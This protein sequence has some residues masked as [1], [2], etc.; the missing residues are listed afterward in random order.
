VIVTK[1]IL[2]LVCLNTLAS[3][4]LFPS[5]APF[6]PMLPQNGESFTYFDIMHLYIY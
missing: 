3:V 6:I 4:M 2:F 1:L 5:V